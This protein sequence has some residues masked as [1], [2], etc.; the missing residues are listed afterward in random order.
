MSVF[1]ELSCLNRITIRYFLFFV[2]ILL[3]HPNAIAEESPGYRVQLLIFQNAGDRPQREEAPYQALLTEALL[4]LDRN[5][6]GIEV[7]SS[8]G[9]LAGKLAAIYKKLNT[10]ADYDVLFVGHW[11]LRQKKG[12]S[13]AAWVELTT[14]DGYRFLT[15]RFHLTA[16]HLLFANVDIVFHDPNVVSSSVRTLTPFLLNET[17]RIRLDEVHYFDHPML[18]VILTVHRHSVTK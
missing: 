18:G 13:K 9:G 6:E 17:R 12:N 7:S 15:G 1:L 8:S 16:G 11:K 5:R 2:F 14:A 10:S 3:I 4:N